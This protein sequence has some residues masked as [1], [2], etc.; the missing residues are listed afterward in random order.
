MNGSPVLVEGTT[1]HR[2]T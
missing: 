1:G 2:R